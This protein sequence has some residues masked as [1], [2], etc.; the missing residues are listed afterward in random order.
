MSGELFGNELEPF[1]RTLGT[2]G[3][4]PCCPSHSARKQS[5]RCSEQQQNSRTSVAEVVICQA[6]VIK[7]EFCS[8]NNAIIFV[9]VIVDARNFD[10]TAPQGCLLH[11]N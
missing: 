9:R 2:E 7:I 6:D 3:W 8:R 11:H 10:S 1:E 5:L 4:L